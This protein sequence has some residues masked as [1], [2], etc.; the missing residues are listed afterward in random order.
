M[1]APRPGPW[2]VCLLSPSNLRLQQVQPRQGWGAPPD[3]PGGMGGPR[4]PAG[5][6][7][8][9]AARLVFL[10]LELLLQVELLRLQVVDALARAPGPSPCAGQERW[11]ARR[12]PPACIRIL[13]PGPASSPPGPRTLGLALGRGA[14]APQREGE[15]SRAPPAKKPQASP[16]KPPQESGAAAPVTEA[17]RPPEVQPRG[18]PTSAGLRLVVDGQH[19][20][21]LSQNLLLL[22][23]SV[24][25]HFCLPVWRE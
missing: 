25:S 4:P 16:P 2:E 3:R 21:P 22:L 13:T 17:G 6:G 24:S 15:G 14:G 1:G 5:A 10:L 23:C 11:A 12:P 20:P 19:L 7:R 8:G 18:Q 9:A